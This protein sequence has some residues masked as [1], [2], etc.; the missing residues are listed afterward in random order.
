MQGVY[1]RVKPDCF[2]LVNDDL[3]IYE[4]D[5][6]QETN[7]NSE[8]EIDLPS[9]REGLFCD[10]PVFDYDGSTSTVW[11]I[12]QGALVEIYV[13][14]R[15]EPANNCNDTCGARQTILNINQVSSQANVL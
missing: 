13:E 9:K 1:I 4:S 15:R 8:F 10:Y 5:Y 14:L 11:D 12:S 2:T 6:V 3:V 7:K